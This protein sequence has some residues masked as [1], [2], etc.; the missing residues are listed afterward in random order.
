MKIGKYYKSL[1]SQLLFISKTSEDPIKTMKKDSSFILLD[2][3]KLGSN[4][5]AIFKILFEG[6]MYYFDSYPKE[7]LE[8]EIVYENSVK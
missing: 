5:F 4:D 7:L 6:K 3:F 8:I 1:S 2:W